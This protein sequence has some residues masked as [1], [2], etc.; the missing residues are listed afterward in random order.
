MERNFLVF[1]LSGP[2]AAFGDAAI[3]ERR[4][5]WDAPSKSGVI[6]I[7][8]GALGYV[9]E[10]HARLK[11]LDSGLGFA[12]RIDQAGRQLR[13]F[14]TAQAPREADRTRRRKLGHDLSTRTGDLK[15]AKSEIST[16]VS[17]RFY[18]TGATYSIAL[19][20]KSNDPAG[21]LKAYAT[22]LRTPVFAPYLGRK[23]CPLGRPAAPLIVQTERLVQAFEAY[24]RAQAQAES[25]LRLL[26]FYPHSASPSDRATIW[27]ELG[28][29]LEGDD[30]AAIERRQRR[31]SLRDHSPWHFSD[32]WEGRLTGRS[33]GDQTFDEALT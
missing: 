30:G 18:R 15:T 31:D 13:D 14:Q 20:L 9:R 33:P 7:V 3:G 19:W 27:F 26:S 16:M 22:A 5:L 29:G 23:A 11:A 32:R 17:E 1:R 28:A 24:D 4:T 21:E 25:H 12:V 8:A 6:G 10:D 2:M